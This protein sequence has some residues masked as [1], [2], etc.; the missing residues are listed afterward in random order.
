MYI[1]KR[2][3]EHTRTYRELSPAA[4]DVA[5]STLIMGVLEAVETDFETDLH[6]NLRGVD[7][8][9]ASLSRHI[10]LN[11]TIPRNSRRSNK[12]STSLAVY[13]LH[14]MLRKLNAYESVSTRD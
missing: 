3:N 4:G 12:S 7:P 2:Q 8:I 9:R 5:N 11:E 10:K 14:H 6:D 1:Y 13:F